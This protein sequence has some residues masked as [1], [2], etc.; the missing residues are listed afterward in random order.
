MKYREALYSAMKNAMDNYEETIIIGQGVTDFKGIFGT[1]IGLKDQ[2]PE[3]V[4]ET[5]LAEDSSLG[6]CIGAALGGLYP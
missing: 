5:P 1:T 6:I 4:I 3:R 2:Y